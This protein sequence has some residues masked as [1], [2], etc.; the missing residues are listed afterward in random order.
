MRDVLNDIE[1]WR[2]RGEQVAVATVVSMAG[3]APRRP[4]A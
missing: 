1:R 2:A 4:G 3:S